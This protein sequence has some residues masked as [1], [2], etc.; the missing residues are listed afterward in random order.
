MLQTTTTKT[1]WFPSKLVSKAWE[2]ISKIIIAR[3]WNI[4]FDQKSRHKPVWET[5]MGDENSN[6][7]LKNIPDSDDVNTRDIID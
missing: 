4:L 1:G 7:L 3:S 6:P 5:K 2:D